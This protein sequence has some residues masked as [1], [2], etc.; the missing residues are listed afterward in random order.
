MRAIKG[1]F[2]DLDGTLLDTAADFVV[3]VNQMLNDYQHPPLD[4]RI[5]RQNISNGSR[6]LMQLAFNLPAGPELERKRALFLDYYERYINDS[7]RITL[8]QPFP[9]IL[10]LLVELE[11]RDIVWG[12][13]TNKPKPYTLLL[14]KQAGLMERSHAIVCPED[15]QQPKPHPQALCLACQQA[16]CDPGHSVYVGDHARDVEA[17]KRAGMITV[18]AH[19]GYIGENDDPLSWQADANIYQARDLHHWLEKLNWQLPTIDD[20]RYTETIT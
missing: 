19:Y 17:G 12:I 7:D 10:P 15:V 20:H 6:R 9:G 18:A 16:G 3:T 14:I 8:A 2:F 13:V 11:R 1:V 5:I 4:A